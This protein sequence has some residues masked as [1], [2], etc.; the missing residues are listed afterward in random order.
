MHTSSTIKAV[1]FDCDGTLVDSEGLCNQ[2][3]VEL[4][5]EIGVEIALEDLVRDYRGRKLS[6]TLATLESTFSITLDRTFV[7]RYRQRV[8]ELFDQQL[9]PTEGIHDA[10]AAINRKM[11]V[12]SSGPMHK[13]RQSLSLCRLLDHFNDHIYSSFEVGFWKPDP[14]VYLHA[15]D[16]IGV[17]P[18]HC[19]VVEDSQVG[20]QAGIRA[21][22]KTFFYNRFDEPL[23]N[24]SV[25][26][27]RDMR[28]L[29]SL[30]EGH[31]GGFRFP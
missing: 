16:A 5:G 24:D 19:A 26:S 14:R 7:P 27:F 30:I 15:A 18:E 28:E 11:A 13:I 29:P 10:L 31:A 3:L 4:L 22:M 6:E 12:V 21:G 9:Q 23:P 17:P 1:L 25:V 20:V 2:G 8:S